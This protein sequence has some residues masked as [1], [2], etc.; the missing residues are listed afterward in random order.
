MGQQMLR[1][2]LAVI[3]FF[4]LLNSFLLL[5][6][7]NTLPCQLYSVTQLSSSYHL[8]ISFKTVETVISLKHNQEIN[9]PVLLACEF[10]MKIIGIIWVLVFK[11]RVL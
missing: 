6:E 7:A 8:R 9:M 10:L 3:G 5:L 1:S 4:K 11:I 2:L